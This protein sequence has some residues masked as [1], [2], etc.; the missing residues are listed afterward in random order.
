MDKYFKYNLVKNTVCVSRFSQGIVPFSLTH[1]LLALLVQFGIKAILCYWSQVVLYPNL[2]K[3]KKRKEKK[4]KKN[5]TH[6]VFN[7]FHREIYSKKC[8]V[9]IYL[10]FFFVH[11]PLYF[12]QEFLSVG[13]IS[14]FIYLF[15]QVLE[16]VVRP[17]SIITLSNELEQ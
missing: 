15:L 4:R 6:Q 11:R 5:Y 9:A 17:S 10:S 8:S 3:E 14:C 7:T 12:L 13:I 2:G 1:K 16:T